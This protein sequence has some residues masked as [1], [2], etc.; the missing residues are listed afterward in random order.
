MQDIIMEL[1][2][3]VHANPSSSWSFKAAAY[4]FLPKRRVREE[5]R[6]GVR[7]RERARERGG[8]KEGGMRGVGEKGG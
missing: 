6:E 2:F 1:W 3:S 4:F 5:K 7:K 8:K